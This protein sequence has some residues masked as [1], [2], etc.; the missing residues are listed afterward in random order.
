[1]QKKIMK[2]LNNKKKYVKQFKLTRV[3]ILTS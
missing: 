3:S 1:M 2:T